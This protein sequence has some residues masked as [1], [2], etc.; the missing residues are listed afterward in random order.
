MSDPICIP[1]Q[2]QHALTNDQSKYESIKAKA[3]EEA[4]AQ[5]LARFAMVKTV[6]DN[7]G[8]MW[9]PIGHPDIERLGGAT[10]HIVPALPDAV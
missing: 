3:I 5:G 1:C 4:R 10:Y 7:P 9:R 6:N 8:F 2:Q